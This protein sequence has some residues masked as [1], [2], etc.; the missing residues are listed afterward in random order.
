MEGIF[1]VTGLF[2]V[3]FFKQV[4]GLELDLSPF[5]TNKI[6]SVPAIIIVIFI[7][8]EPVVLLAFVC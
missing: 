6:T 5:P 2:G 3:L 8:G 7:S 1:L 4:L